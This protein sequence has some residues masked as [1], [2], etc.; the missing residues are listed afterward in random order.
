MNQIIKILEESN[1]RMRKISKGGYEMEE[2]RLA[3]AEANIQI[4]TVNLVVQ[5]FAVA[6]KNK[7]ALPGLY[8]M[9]L[10]DP[11]TAVDLLLGDPELDKLKCPE[12]DGGLITRAECLDYAGSHESCTNCEEKGE[13]NNRLLDK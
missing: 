2:M 9:G 3:Q 5:A 13:T 7:R 4:K 11:H 6:S 1:R 12:R 10:M 8:K